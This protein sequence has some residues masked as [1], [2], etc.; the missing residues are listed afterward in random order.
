MENS[1]AHREA[2]LP[3]DK[4]AAFF[5]TVS[6]AIDDKTLVKLLLSNRRNKE[7][8]LKNINISIVLLKGAYYLSFVYKYGAKDIAKN[9]QKDDG[10]ER[11]KQA[12]EHD[13]FNADLYTETSIVNLIIKQNKRTQL[14]ITGAP[15]NVTNNFSHDKIKERLIETKDNVYLERLGIVDAQWNVRKGMN[16]KYRQINRYIELLKPYLTDKLL[17]APCH[18]ADMGSGKGYLTFALYDYITNTLKKT[19]SMTGVELR[20]E[21]VCQCN[22]IAAEMQFNNLQFVKGSIGDAEI[23]G[24]DILIALHACDT[25]TDDALYR[26][27]KS[28]ASL[29]VCVPCCHKQIRNEIRAAGAFGGIVKHGILKERQAEIITDALRAM[30]LE[31][32]NYRTNVIEFI[33]SEH[34]AKNVMIIGEKRANAHADTIE[35]AKNISSIKSMFGIKTFYLEALLGLFHSPADG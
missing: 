24:M 35:I 19:V 22:D 29:I 3:H 5:D 20:E 14:R 18:I 27:I 1:S 32:Y 26:G 21:L 30:T 7:S 25:A 9:Y 2:S 23:G 12:V 17:A 13:F 34:T 28:N 31:Y 16:D 33:S 4:L 15:R 6:L 10:L 11:I 8:D